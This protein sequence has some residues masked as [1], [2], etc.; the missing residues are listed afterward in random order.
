ML[1]NK[2]SVEKSAPIG[3]VLMWFKDEAPNNWLILDGSALSRTSYSE[4]F[5]LYGTKYG[6]GDGTTTFNLPDLRG[7]VPVGKSTTDSDINEIGKKYGE[8]T[9]TLSI[10]EMP[11]H[12]HK[13]IVGSNINAAGY[14]FMVGYGGGVPDNTYYGSENTGGSLPHNN[15]QPSIATNFI[16]KAKEEKQTIELPEYIPTFLKCTKTNPQTFNKDYQTLT[17]NNISGD[18]EKIKIQNNKILIDGDYKIV[19][20]NLYISTN[21]IFPVNQN[22][23]IT[24]ERNGIITDT[25]NISLLGVTSNINSFTLDVQKGD[26]INIELAYNE[27]VTINEDNYTYLDIIAF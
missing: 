27:T 3:S 22:I 23:K 4:L 9:H 25:K 20:I 17:F 12:S 7:Y 18:Q 1:E 19:N 14:R 16:I 24:K 2:I 13:R 5:E 10:D 8:K 11:K 15:M 21:K 26:L 6:E